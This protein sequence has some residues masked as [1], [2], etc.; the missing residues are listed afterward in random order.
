MDNL[1]QAMLDTRNGYVAKYDENLR[2]DV[3]RAFNV[4]MSWLNSLILSDTKLRATANSNPVSFCKVLANVVSAGLTLSPAMKFCYVIVRKEN[5]KPAAT[6]D[7]SYMGLIKMITDNGVVSKVE[8]NVV[9]EGDVFECEYGLDPK[10][11]H[12]PA[13]SNRGAMVAAYCIAHIRGAEPQIELLTA[14]DMADI[15]AAS[16]GGDVWFKWPGEMWRKSAVKRA[17]KYMPKNTMSDEMIAG[18]AIEYRND[19]TMLGAGDVSEEVLEE[20]FEASDAPAVLAESE[21]KESAPAK[22][23]DKPKRGRKAKTEAKNEVKEAAKPE[24][25]VESTQNEEFVVTTVE[26]N[27]VVEVTKESKSAPTREP[28][29]GSHVQP[30]AKLVEP[31]QPIDSTPGQIVQGG[32]MGIMQPIK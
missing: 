2:P 28:I 26:P 13:L 20:I 27:D 10:F 22:S 18:L 21:Q 29:N 23:T 8:A 7:I 32:L 31:T 1:K 14:D 5:G 6:L 4:E 19:N 16:Q 11:R 30:E 25:V 17:F 15:K 9:Y 3:E 24:P 12:V